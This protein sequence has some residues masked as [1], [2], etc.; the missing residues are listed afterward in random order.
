MRDPELGSYR[1][2]SGLWAAMV[3][4]AANDNAI[5][6]AL[7]I[8]ISVGGW[9]A[10]NLDPVLWANAAA[11]CFI[12]PFILFASPAARLARTQ[13]AKHWLVQLKT[14]EIVL[15]LSALGA[16]WVQSAP[17]LLATVAGF[18]VQSA[19]IGPLKYALIPRVSTP[20]T[21]LRNNAWMEAGTFVAILMGTLL[22]ADWV[23]AHPGALMT[24]SIALAG[25][26]LL[27]LRALPDWPAQSS[28]HTPGFRTLITQVAQIPHQRS[29]IWCLSGF[30]AVGSVWLTHLP[31][32]ATDHWGLGTQAVSWLL[33]LF[34]VGVALGALVG[35]FSGELEI[36]HR[37][38]MGALVLLAGS[39][40]VWSSTGSMGPVGLV[41][42][43]AGGGYLA[44]PL[45]TA[46]QQNA[47]AVS[48]C[49]AVNNIANAALIVSAA[50]ASMVAVSGLGWSVPLWLLI[51]ATTQ[52]LVCLYHRGNLR[53]D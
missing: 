38:L 16:L 9:R 2:F 25:I 1:A 29:A 22:G 31:W 32:L 40:W 8:A 34:V 44:L 45:Y 43:A 7:V 50:L 19:F 39:L 49:I 20:H 24:L 53:L 3:A 27:A 15:A 14:F 41:L 33:A 11:L 47:D 30:W 21:L 42:A 36:V 35:A 4:G 52:L 18:G 6:T 37:V 13:P 23:L 46:L 10:F 12:A 5:K 28:A 17:W 48:D 51:L 26:G